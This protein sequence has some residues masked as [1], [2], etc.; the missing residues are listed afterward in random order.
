ME[1]G[2][3]SGVTLCFCIHFFYKIFYSYNHL[4]V[5]TLLWGADMSGTSSEH[6][7]INKSRKMV[8]D[9]STSGV[10]QVRPG[11]YTVA[12]ELG[13]IAGPGGAREQ[14]APLAV[15]E[16]GPRLAEG[17]VRGY[18]G[19]PHAGPFTTGSDGAA[20]RSGLVSSSPD[21]SAGPL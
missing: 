15:Q 17:S 2:P 8:L 6:P 5:A 19:G 20:S 1:P 14:W 7:F 16:N 11:L 4:T 18:G 9:L 13:S 21:V 3:G 12:D 10:A